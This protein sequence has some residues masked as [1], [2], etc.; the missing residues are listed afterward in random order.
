MIYFL[1]REYLVQ[2]W[3]FQNVWVSQ[4]EEWESIIWSLNLSWEFQSLRW[5]NECFWHESNSESSVSA[6]NFILSDGKKENF[7]PESDF[8][9]SV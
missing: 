5:E 6:E 7:L 1:G 4:E 9:S 8:E 2:Q 3:A